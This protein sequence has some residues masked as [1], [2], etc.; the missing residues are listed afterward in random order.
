[1][2]HDVPGSRSSSV[3]G[4]L[5]DVQGIKRNGS[6]GTGNWP[7]GDELAVTSAFLLAIHAP[8]VDGPEPEAGI[9]DG[10]AAVA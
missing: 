9:P 6:L 10:V 1:L 7:Y 5:V 8:V 4:K 2:A 3:G